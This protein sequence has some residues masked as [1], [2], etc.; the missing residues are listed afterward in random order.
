MLLE[1]RDPGVAGAAQQ[2]EQVAGQREVPEVVAPE[3]QLEAILGG[4]ALR[5]LHDAGVVDQDVDGPALGV[6]LVTERGDAGQ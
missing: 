6:Q 4:F 3:L 2:R 5:R 1:R